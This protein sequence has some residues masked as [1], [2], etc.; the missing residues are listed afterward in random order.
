MPATPH[1][2]DIIKNYQN[3]M[4]RPVKVLIPQWLAAINE[5]AV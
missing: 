2:W 3:N 5:A 1:K 4:P